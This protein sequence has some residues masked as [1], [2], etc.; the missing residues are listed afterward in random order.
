MYNVFYR[1]DIAVVLENGG[2]IRYENRDDR[3]L[4]L[5]EGKWPEEVD[6]LNGKTTKESYVFHWDMRD[7]YYDC[8]TSICPSLPVYV[9]D[10]SK[11]VS[12][13]LS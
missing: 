9:P 6:V 3:F 13:S 10:T 7:P 1:V 12:S 2:Y 11:S 4:F 5:K 8:S